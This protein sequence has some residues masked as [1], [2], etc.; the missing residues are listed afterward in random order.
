MISVC[1][2]HNCINFFV[3]MTK[4]FL[5]QLVCNYTVFFGEKNCVCPNFDKMSHHRI[6]CICAELRSNID[7]DGETIVQK[8]GWVPAKSLQCL[9]IKRTVENINLGPSIPASLICFNI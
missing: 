8:G 7:S 2:S 1:D 6:F 5:M 4:A 9:F 3:I